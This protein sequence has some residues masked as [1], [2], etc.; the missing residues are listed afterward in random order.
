MSFDEVAS[1]K[2]Q[3]RHHAHVGKEVFF[4]RDAFVQPAG[5]ASWNALRDMARLGPLLPS[6][7][8][9]PFANS[10]LPITYFVRIN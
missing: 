8:Y 9:S 7:D 5:S 4:S 10:Y 6:A 3:R 1:L 2:L